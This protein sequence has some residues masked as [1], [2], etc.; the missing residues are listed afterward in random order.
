MSADTEVASLLSHAT[1]ATSS[2]ASQSAA[3]VAAAT[4]AIAKVVEM[5]TWNPSFGSSIGVDYG[6]SGIPGFAGAP[7]G[8]AGAP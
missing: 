3:L 2:L 6:D 4:A 7:W 8:F 1:T 5:P